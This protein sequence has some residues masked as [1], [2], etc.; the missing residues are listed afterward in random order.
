MD[1]F[2]NKI[3]FNNIFNITDPV[4]IQTINI[5]YR[6][7]FLVDFIFSDLFTDIQRNEINTYLNLH[8]NTLICFIMKNMESLFKHLHVFLV[9]KTNAVG[10]FF[11]EL[12]SILKLSMNDLK[13][14]FC[15]V[16]VNYHYHVTVLSVLLEQIK[17][18][19]KIEIDEDRKCIILTCLEILA[20]VVK[21]KTSKIATIFWEK[22][23]GNPCLME[24]LPFLILKSDIN[25]IDMILDMLQINFIL[26]TQEPHN[27]ISFI[28]MKLIPTLSKKVRHMCN[29]EK[30]TPTR[31]KLDIQNSQFDEKSQSEFILQKSFSVKNEKR[32]AQSH[33]VYESDRMAKSEMG[34]ICEKRS[35]T[36][37]A[38]RRRKSRVEPIST[39]FINS[40]LTKFIGFVIESFNILFETKIEGNRVFSNTLIEE[41]VIELVSKFAEKSTSKAFKILYIK[42]F[43]NLILN[44]NAN[45]KNLFIDHSYCIKVLWS[46]FLDNYRVGNQNLFYSL[47]MATFKM[48]KE[49]NTYE[50]ITSLAQRIDKQP[51]VCGKE[52]LLEEIHILAISKKW[53]VNEIESKLQSESEMS[54]IKLENKRNRKISINEGIIGPS[55]EFMIKKRNKRNYVSMDEDKKKSIRKML[56]QMKEQKKKQEGRN[57]IINKSV[58]PRKED[59]P[60]ISINLDNLLNKRGEM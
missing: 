32:L 19:E 17:D 60:D 54:S 49:S 11:H 45:S 8:G 30:N 7:A 22:V 52:P 18:I 12:F 39:S 58:E 2:E 15:N 57:K 1:L 3:K 42:Y 20:F 34:S 51:I 48:I 55:M 16:F 5:Q 46:I 50:L 47:S 33:S 38:Q 37:S 53:L 27:F 4:I 40:G 59:K 28:N 25:M 41:N 9:E 43:K 35:I 6:I 21:T 26:T 56:D 23:N 29:D 14:T 10:N 36:S 24:K 31:P 13:E 44:C